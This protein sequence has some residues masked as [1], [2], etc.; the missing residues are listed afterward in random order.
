VQDY[1]YGE[2]L[3]KL[4]QQANQIKKLTREA[5]IQQSLMDKFTKNTEAKEA[6]NNALTAATARQKAHIDMLLENCPNIIILLDDAGQFVLSTDVFLTL[7][8]IPNFDYIKKRSYKEVFFKY[9]SP[10]VITQF[11]T[12]L[13]TVFTSNRKVSFDAWVEFKL[14][15]QRYYSVQMQ[16]AGLVENEPAGIIII[17]ND[18]TDFLHE[19][20]KSEDANRAKTE[21]LAHVSHEIRTPITTVMG[22]SELELQLGGLSPH[23]KDSFTRIFN[24]SNHLLRIINDISDVSQIEAGEISLLPETY[25][26]ATMVSDVTQRHYPDLLEESVD[27]TLFVDETLPKFLLGDELRIKQIIKNL[28]TSAFKLTKQGGVKLVLRCEKGA[29]PTYIYLL[30]TVTDTGAALAPKDISSAKNGEGLGKGIVYR[31]AQLMDAEV[32]I[33]SIEKRGTTV[34]VKIPQEIVDAEVLGGKTAERLENF[35]AV[36]VPDVAISFIPERMPYGKILVVDD[37]EANLHVINGMLD[38]YCLKVELC[39]NSM[40]AIAKVKAGKVYDIIFMDHVMPPPD[41]METMQVLR[42][43]GYTAPI[44]ALTANAFA[45][46]AE[47][48]IKNGFNDFLSK[49]IQ[50]ARL[51]QVLNTYVRDRR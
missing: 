30:I 22:L 5:A 47:E 33:E 40:D 2:L 38:I 16:P 15:E 41:G 46:Q 43:L 29:K 4:D 7:T 1:T 26:T 12:A 11:K 32:T 6:L 20:Q 39:R 18:L 42:A 44:I 23:A 28:L 14:L 45:G 8:G 37:L 49:P 24:A 17:M 25:D 50:S 31:L 9:L 35:E 48:F 3:T 34:T 51:N 10:D 27:F 19:K 36:D 13:Q 21:F